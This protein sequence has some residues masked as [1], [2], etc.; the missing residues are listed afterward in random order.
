[1]ESITEFSNLENLETHIQP[2]DTTIDYREEFLN[3]YK[4]YNMETNTVDD[5]Y[6]YE[7]DRTNLIKYCKHIIDT[8]YA[9]YPEPMSSI[10]IKRMYYNTIR[11]MNKEEYLLEKKELSEMSLVDKELKLLN[12]NENLNNF[13][14]NKE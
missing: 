6:I 8:S 3:R 2:T 7:I 11:A 14:N 1:M 13:L 12:Q 9:M 4:D 5:S 10:L